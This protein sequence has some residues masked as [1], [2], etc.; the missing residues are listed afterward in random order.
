M[1]QFA[2]LLVAV[3]LVVIGSGASFAQD[4]KNG[5]CQMPARIVE[6]VE[7]VAATSIIVASKPTSIVKQVRT[8]KP[9]RTFIRRL[10]RR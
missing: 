5:Q 10:F 9:V 2:L 1:R 8:K 6:S 7:T 3:L 4:C